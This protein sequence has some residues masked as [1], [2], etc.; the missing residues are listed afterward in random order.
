MKRIEC[1]S[2]TFNA[3]LGECRAWPFDV[4]VFRKLLLAVVHTTPTS[5]CFL[6]PGDHFRKVPFSKS[7]TLHHLGNVAMFHFGL[8]AWLSNLSGLVF[9][10]VLSSVFPNACCSQGGR[11]FL[12]GCTC[13]W[14]LPFIAWY[15]ASS[16]Q[17]AHWIVVMVTQCALSVTW[18]FQ[19]TFKS[20][21]FL[22]L[23][24]TMSE[25]SQTPATLPVTCSLKSISL[26]DDIPMCRICCSTGGKQGGQE[27]L[28]RVCLCK[29][30]MGEIHK[31]CLE[32][33]LT[34]AHADRCPI[35]HYEFQIRRVFKP[36]TQVST[37]I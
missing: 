22:S 3:V 25:S 13:L 14:C 10:L 33:W 9:W 30:S 18:L 6:Y 26:E 29:G 11:R 24:T 2:F 12:S 1:F 20:L 31:S 27:P 19:F 28:L 17:H 7:F 34:A 4:S 32:T 21:V 8:K 36:I 37:R 35:C 5:R 15:R 23:T 16:R